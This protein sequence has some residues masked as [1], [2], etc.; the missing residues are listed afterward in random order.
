MGEGAQAAQLAGMDEGDAP[1]VHPPPIPRVVIS[2]S[3]DSDE[4]DGRAGVAPAVDP[5]SDA[6]SEE[7]PAS[8]AAYEGDDEPVDDVDTKRGAWKLCA[9]AAPAEQRIPIPRW[10]GESSDVASS[11]QHYD[12]MLDEREEE[13]RNAVGQHF[14]AIEFFEE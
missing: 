13:F 2:V 5:S 6:A 11:I 4:D 8:D 14:E 1:D 3:S 7:R 10:Y 9:G 12:A